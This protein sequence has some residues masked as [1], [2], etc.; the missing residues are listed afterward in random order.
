MPISPRRLALKYTAVYMLFFLP[1]SLLIDYAL[2]ILMSRIKGAR[3]P[4][5]LT[6]SPVAETLGTSIWAGGFAY[7]AFRNLFDPA[8]QR[9]SSVHRL[10]YLTLPLPYHAAFRRCLDSLQVVGKP[11]ILVENRT[12]GVIEAAILPDPLWKLLLMSYGDRVQIH[13]GSNTD[14][15]TAV[16]IVSRS[17][18]S[19]AIF[20]SRH[21]ERNVRR[22]AS[23][24]QDAT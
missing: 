1:F 5:A 13:L 3:R 23:F 2:D 18:L 9:S 22:I 24:L 16:K 7:F 4:F 10:T 14:R 17:S 21:H 8:Y 6:L 15:E 19:R 11:T 12:R 20:G